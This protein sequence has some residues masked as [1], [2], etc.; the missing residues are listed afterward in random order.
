MQS[1]GNYNAPCRNLQKEFAAGNVVPDDN[2]AF[3]WQMRNITF[4]ADTKDQWMPDKG[5]G[6]EY[7]IDG[8]VS[9]I[10]AYG[11]LLF[12]F[13]EPTGPSV[14]VFEPTEDELAE[15]EKK[16]GTG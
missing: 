3:R 15:L 1:H 8:G 11:L 13:E 6:R 5:I 2:P 4:K 12:E 7:K 10:M 9:V 16:W 14:S